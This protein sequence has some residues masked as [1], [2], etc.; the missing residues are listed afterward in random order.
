MQVVDGDIYD[1][2]RYYDLVYG[3]DWKAE[4]DFLEDCFE[5]HVEHVVESV[6]EPACGTG[7]L[8]YRF[9]KVGYQVAGNDLNEKAIDFCNQR[10][11]RH[12]LAGTARVGDMCDFKLKKKVDSAFNTINSF[13]HL[14]SDHLAIAHL[15]CMAQ[16][17]RKGGIYVLG[18]HLV[19]EKGPRC[20]DESWSASRGHL[21]VNSRLWLAERNLAERYEAYNM[22]FDVYTPTRQFQIVD[23]VRFRTYTAEQFKNLLFQVPGFE[24]DAIYD[25]A[26]DIEEPILIDEKTED[27]V[28]I[29]K[30]V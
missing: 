2:P 19:P 20:E 23:Q 9:G 8:L 13:R 7:R 4:F 11:E 29:L 30:A 21:T 26:Y 5:R 14:A 16:A 12:G 17:I 1:Y 24:V 6:F 15:N 3:S 18:F 22:S 27:I 25:F 28:Y 10:L